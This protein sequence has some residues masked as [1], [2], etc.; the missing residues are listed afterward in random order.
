MTQPEVSIIV[1]CHNEAAMLPHSMR[2]VEQQAESLPNQEVIVVVNGSTD[3]SADIARG[4]DMTTPVR[5][6][7]VNAPG[8]KNAMNIGMAVARSDFLVFADADSLMPNDIVFNAIN[9]LET[10]STRLVG[11]P[12]MP[13]YPEGI[14]F[15]EFE[16]SSAFYR[17]NY[18]RRMARPDQKT[19]Q[20]WFMAFNRRRLNQE[21][22]F[23]QGASPDDTWLSAYIGSRH[24]I[25]SISYLS[26][27][28]GEYIPPM[29]EDDMLA[30]A[31]RHSLCRRL[32]RLEHPEVGQYFDQV[33]QYN[34]ET[35][36][37]HVF[38][39]RWRQEVSRMGLDFDKW[40]G[41]YDLFTER[42]KEHADELFS[43]LISMNGIWKRIES[44]KAPPK[45]YKGQRRVS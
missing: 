34:D 18:A 22:I 14:E 39:E 6:I 2:T 37:P 3:N 43:T 26:A 21:L 10:D 33:E 31:A 16:F 11:A 29:N 12:R 28:P 41:K 25:E 42:V 36:P 15:D 13:L 19:V 24:G 5:V 44:T 38:M 32:V 9:S 30:Q 40:S 1:S 17:M 7:E 4:Y 20:G 45:G 23:P 8:K 35:V 27:F